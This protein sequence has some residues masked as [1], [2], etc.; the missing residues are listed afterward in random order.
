ML[1]K[2]SAGFKAAPLLKALRAAAV[3][4]LPPKAATATAAAD[5]AATESSQGSTAGMDAEAHPAEEEEEVK[6]DEGFRRT[7]TLF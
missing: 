2:G 4:A 7:D 1:Q 3:M 5:A 6:V